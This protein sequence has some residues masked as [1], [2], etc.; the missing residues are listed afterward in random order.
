LNRRWRLLLLGIA[1]LAVA[2][3]AMAAPSCPPRAC[4][5]TV[6]RCLAPE[7]TRHLRKA[8]KQRL[9]KACRRFRPEGTWVFASANGA[10]AER[11]TI[12]RRGPALVATQPWTTGTDATVTLDGEHDVIDHP[13]DGPRP[14]ASLRDRVESERMPDRRL[15]P[16]RLRLPARTLGGVPLSSAMRRRAGRVQWLLRDGHDVPHYDGRL[17]ELVHVLVELPMVVAAAARPRAL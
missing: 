7:D 1:T 4:P 3:A 10:F 16:T 17:H 6:D 12:S 15:V 9:R 5:A 2:A 13:D 14:A 11:F 8:C